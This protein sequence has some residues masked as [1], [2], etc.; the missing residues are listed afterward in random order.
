MTLNP[1]NFDPC[2]EVE[3]TVRMFRDQVSARDI[4]L[5]FEQDESIN[6]LQVHQV[7]GDN[8]RFIQV[9]V[10]LISNAIKFTE[11]APRRVIR[12]RFGAAYAPEKRLES[13]EDEWPSMDQEDLLPMCR[14]SPAPVMDAKLRLYIAIS[15]S[16]LGMADDEQV[17]LFQRF[18][19]ASPR[20][21]GQF[22]GSGLGL[23]R[24]LH[25][26]HVT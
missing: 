1:S 4:Q 16:G 15:D 19:Q 7:W 20:T 6:A 18:V 24:R 3:N 17:R 8:G 9:I 26:P 5:H 11:P 13:D 10:N 2:K 23:V 21:Y 12:V 22:G 14:Q 25:Q